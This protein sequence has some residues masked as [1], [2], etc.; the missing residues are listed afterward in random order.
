LSRTKTV[1]LRKHKS[2]SSYSYIVTIPKALVESALKW[3]P[4]D[5]LK[6]EEYVLPDK[7]GILIYKDG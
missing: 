6:V 3:N 2:G 5:E 1:K 7:R 4:G